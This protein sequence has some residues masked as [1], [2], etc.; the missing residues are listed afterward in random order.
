MCNNF[1]NFG[2]LPYSEEHLARLA[3]ISDMIAERE[4]AFRHEAY[5]Q[6][7]EKDRECRTSLTPPQTKP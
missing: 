1:S 7:R 3:K 2:K 6:Q 4:A 5:V